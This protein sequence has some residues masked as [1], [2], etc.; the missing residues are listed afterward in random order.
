MYGDAREVRCI[1]FA[2]DVR[3][4]VVCLC[5]VPVQPSADVGLGASA[6]AGFVPLQNPEARRKVHFTYLNLSGASLVQTSNA[7]SCHAR[8]D[9]LHVRLMCAQR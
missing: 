7:R 8:S 4:F 3:V 6:G 2:L 9:T 1:L 5:L